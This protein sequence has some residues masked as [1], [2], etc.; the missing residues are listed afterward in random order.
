MV[1]KSNCVRALLLFAT[2]LSLGMQSGCGREEREQIAA[3][4]GADSVQDVTTSVSSKI[5]QGKFQE[6]REEGEAFLDGDADSGGRLAWLLAQACAQLG[7]RDQAI[8]YVSQAIKARVVDGV[9]VMA[10]PM[11]GPIHADIR[12]VP[13]AAGIAPTANNTR[14]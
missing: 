1:V 13:L 3:A 5:G 9:Q 6:A 7:D 14:P 12:L 4:V 10:E 8:A 2:L 11:L